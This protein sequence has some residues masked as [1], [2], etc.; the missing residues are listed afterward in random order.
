MLTLTYGVLPSYTAFRGRFEAS[1]P[2]GDYHIT[3]SA[4]DK[5]MAARVGL[6]GT[7]DG[8]YLED[9][10]DVVSL[11]RAFKVLAFEWDHHGDDGAGDF[12]SCILQTLGIEWI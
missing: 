7:D 11:W 5:A 6:D 2:S 1:L 8:G 3:L 10:H 9:T 4:S 12:A